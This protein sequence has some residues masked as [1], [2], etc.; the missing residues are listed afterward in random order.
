ME[1]ASDSTVRDDSFVQFWNS[2]DILKT[3]PLDELSPAYIATLQAMEKLSEEL[4]ELA[5]R[6]LIISL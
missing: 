4:T 1:V 6:E 5:N 2:G 3:Y